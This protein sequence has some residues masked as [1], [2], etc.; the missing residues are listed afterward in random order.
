MQSAS[1][2]G[3]N[4]DR[5]IRLERSVDPR[6][7]KVNPKSRKDLG[8]TSPDILL[9]AGFWAERRLPQTLR[10]YSL[11]IPTIILALFKLRYIALDTYLEAARFGQHSICLS[12]SSMVS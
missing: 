10:F 7:S 11:H 9:G 8:R 4:I 1:S 6:P 12:A 2:V 5:C 3:A